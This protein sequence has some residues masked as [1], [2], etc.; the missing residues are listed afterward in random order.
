MKQSKILIVDDNP[1]NIYSFQAILNAPE[2]KMLTALSGEEGLKLLLDH[3]DVMLIL[4]D[5]Q[6]PEMDGF[7]T[8]ELIRGQPRFQDI[9]ILFI[10]A[11][12]QD[13]RFAQR[14]FSV[15][16][17]DYITKP[18]DNAILASKVNVFLTLQ[19]QKE[20]LAQAKNVLLAE[21][22]ERKRIEADLR[23]TLTDLERMNR[24]LEQ[25]AYAASHDLQ[26][27]L[28]TMSN[29]VRLLQQ[30]YTDRLD[31]QG[32]MFLNFTVDAATRM[33]AL[34][35]ALLDFSRLR[36]KEMT[37]AVVDCK[38]L[39]HEALTD[40][41]DVIERSGATIHANADLH[42]I[43][44]DILLRR[45]LQNLITNAIKFRQADTPPQIRINVEAKS[46]HWLFSVQDN[47]I[48]IEEKHFERIFEIFRRL[49]SRDEYD[50]TG[51]GLALS[52]KIVELHGGDIWLTSQVGRGSTFFF[53]IHNRAEGKVIS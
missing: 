26:E 6:M 43:G 23:M 4:M 31:E 30:R 29:F 49:H 9:P 53:T 33:K 15:G 52:K 3:P 38:Q 40:L 24:E 17:T 42:I 36:R 18:V 27:P 25:L 34:V 13:S 2:R 44:N 47:G 35:T 48:G 28:N 20:E 5:V 51:L 19:Q 16:G 12:Y 22:E 45:V 7:E 21:I 46:D 10:T 50:G 14:G 11:V 8:A 32:Q 37:V 39:L 1:N 41:T